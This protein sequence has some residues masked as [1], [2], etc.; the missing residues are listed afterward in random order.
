[1]SFDDAHLC[2]PSLMLQLAVVVDPPHTW[3]P[4]TSAILLPLECTTV[5]KIVVIPDHSKRATAM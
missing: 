2:A 4:T 5:L 1:M 3:A